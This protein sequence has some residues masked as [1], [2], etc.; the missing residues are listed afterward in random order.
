MEKD[1]EKHSTLLTDQDYIITIFKKHATVIRLGDNY[2]PVYN[3]KKAVFEVL[4]KP[5]SWHFKLQPCKRIVVSKTKKTGNCVVMGK[6][7]YNENIGEGKSLLKRGK[8]I[9][10]IN[11]NLIP[12]GVQLKPAKLTDLNKLLSKHFMPH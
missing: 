6:L 7:H 2:C 8:K 12:K 11:P 9:T 5:A 3:W 1:V 10:S 4:K